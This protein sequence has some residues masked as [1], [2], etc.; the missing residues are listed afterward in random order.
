MIDRQRRVPGVPPE[1]ACRW[2]VGYLLWHM[3]MQQHD[4]LTQRL[5]SI[6]ALLVNPLAS[7][8]LRTHPNDVWRFDDQD[9]EKGVCVEWRGWWDWA[10]SSCPDDGEENWIT[11]VRYYNRPFHQDTDAD[12]EILRRYEYIPEELSNLIDSIRTLQLERS[13]SRS[14]TQTEAANMSS[15]I[16]GTGK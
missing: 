1:R 6:R 13:P 9:M 14:A 2:A 11:L 15:D 4:T 5:L 12:R 16:P 7:S 10:A 3:L 8:V